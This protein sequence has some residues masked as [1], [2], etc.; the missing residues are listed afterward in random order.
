MKAIISRLINITPFII[1]ILIVAYIVEEILEDTSS[2][3]VS[4]FV[5]PIAGL[6]LL[7]VIWLYLIPTIRAYLNPTKDSVE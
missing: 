3:T 6:L 1:G 4:D 2:E 7:V 5:F